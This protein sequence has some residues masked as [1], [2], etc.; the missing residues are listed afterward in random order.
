MESECLYE[1]HINRDNYDLYITCFGFKELNKPRNT[2]DG[3]VEVTI[4]DNENRELYCNEFQFDKDEFFFTKS[5]DKDIYVCDFKIDRSEIQP[6]DSEFCS[7]SLKF[8]LD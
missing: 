5:V 1:F 6:S 2:T 3:K 7:L 8:K 4:T